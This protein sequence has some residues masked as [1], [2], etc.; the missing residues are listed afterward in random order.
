MP[1]IDEGQPGTRHREIEIEAAIEEDEQQTEGLGR[2]ENTERD[3]TRLGAW[4][5]VEDP[6][7]APPP[8]EIAEKQSDE[9]AADDAHELP[10]LSAAPD[11]G[12]AGFPSE[13]KSSQR[14]GSG[15]DSSRLFRRVVAPAS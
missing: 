5:A 2:H 6:V 1:E 13:D 8:E 4:Q 14:H 10:L 3:A 9:D 15:V 11:E 12:Q 7:G